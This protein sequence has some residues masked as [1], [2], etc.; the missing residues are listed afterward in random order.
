MLLT[1]PDSFDKTYS[2]IAIYEKQDDKEYY[3]KK[4]KLN[5]ILIYLL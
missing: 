2:K 1:I 4:F 5:I 3:R